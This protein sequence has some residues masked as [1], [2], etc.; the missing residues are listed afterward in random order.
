MGTSKKGRSALIGGLFVALVILLQGCMESEPQKHSW[1]LQSQATKSSL[2]FQELEKFAQQ[3]SVMSAGRLE[4]Q[5]YPSGEITSGADI[6]T[7]V[8][9]GRIQMGNGWPNWWSG[10]NPAWALL[11]AGPFDFMNIDAS[12]MFFLSGP[13]V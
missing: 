12:M 11:N 10:N 6:Y 1:Q 4:I 7:A 13:G 9:D 5:V 3:V 8:K 2:D